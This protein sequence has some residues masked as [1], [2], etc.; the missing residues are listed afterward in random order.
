LVMTK[1]LDQEAG[2]WTYPLEF[3]PV[4]VDAKLGVIVIKDGNQE[5]HVIDAERR[6]RKVSLAA[7]P[8]RV[9][10]LALVAHDGPCI[11]ATWDDGV[12]G[13]GIGVARLDGSTI[14]LRY[15]LPEAIRKARAEREDYEEDEEL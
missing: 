4:S 3:A 11:V 14:A 7:F 9:E 1:H 6:P 12:E 5:L 15:A 10:E 13:R 2:A 8:A